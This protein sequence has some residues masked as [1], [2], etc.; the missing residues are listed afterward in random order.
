MVQLSH[1]YMTTGKTALTI[2]TFVN[3]VMSLLFNMLSRFVI[4]FLP[5]SKHFWISW[6]HSLSTVILESK[7]IKSL[8]VSIVFP[9][10]CHEVMELYAMIFIFWMLSFKPAFSLSSF[11]FIPFHFLSL[12][13]YHLHDIWYITYIYVWCIYIFDISSRNLDSSLWFIQNGILHDVI[14]IEVK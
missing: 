8:T 2:W 6:L 1:P 9:S 14:C 3:K 7:K 11:T 12:G 5:R 10:I 4:A 13:C